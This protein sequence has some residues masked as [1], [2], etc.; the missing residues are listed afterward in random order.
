M[1]PASQQL[2]VVDD[3][4]ARVCFP[5][6]RGLHAVVQ[7]LA[8]HAAEMGKR[9][10]VAAQDRRQVL[11]QNELVPQVTAVAQHH[12]KQSDPAYGTLIAKADLELGK[13][14]LGLFAGRR[15]E[16][17]FEDK[18][19]RRTYCAQEVIDCGAAA[20]VALPTDLPQQPL[21]SQFR[22]GG[23]TLA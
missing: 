4:F 11:V 5:Q 22:P 6:N 10:H 18:R 16:P 3:A 15:L 7:N 17:D 19:R 2:G 9:F 1:G 12:G 21:A 13:V 14:D 20:C 23:H 8:W